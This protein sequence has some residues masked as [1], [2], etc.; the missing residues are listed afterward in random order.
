M[1]EREGGGE[2]RGGGGGRQ[3][4]ER[5]EKPARRPCTDLFV[6]ARTAPML[7]PVLRTRGVWRWGG[8]LVCGYSNMQM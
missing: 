6:V 7:S 3:L 5:S 1:A 2:E 8:E 4:F